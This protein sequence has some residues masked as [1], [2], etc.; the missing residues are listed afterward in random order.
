MSEGSKS[1]KKLFDFR[2]LIAFLAMV[3]VGCGGNGGGIGSSTQAT[4][5]HIVFN[6]GH[7][8]TVSESARM[9]DVASVTSVV[10]ANPSIT[11]SK[12]AQ[13]VVAKM[14]S[15]PDFRMGGISTSGD[16]WGEFKDGLLYA[17]DVSDP[18]FFALTP[19]PSAK[20]TFRPVSKTVVA[21]PTSLAST[22]FPGSTKAYIIHGVEDARTSP[23]AQLA[24]E[25]TQAGYSV[26]LTTG[27]VADWSQITHA[28]MLVNDGHGV[29]ILGKF[30]VSTTDS[31]TPLLD[32]QYASYLSTKAMAVAGLAVFDSASKQHIEQRYLLSID[33]LKS[34][35]NFSSMFAP[36]SFFMDVVCSGDSPEA[37]NFWGALQT[38][39]GLG[40]YS[41]WSQPVDEGAATQT[42]D[43]F[44]DRM[45]GLNQA[46][47]VDPSLPP[48]G[49]VAKTAALL[50]T[51]A[52]GIGSSNMDHDGSTNVFSF[53]F[54][55]NLT[56]FIPSI[57]SVAP[58]SDGSKWLV[59]GAFGADAGT[60]TYGGAPVAPVSWTDSEIV[61]PSQSTTGSVV[62]K[63]PTGLISNAFTPLGKP[64]LSPVSSQIKQ[65]GQQALKVTIG[66]GLKGA[67]YAYKWTNSAKYGTIAD[68]SGHKGTT[69]TSSNSSVTYTPSPNLYGIDNLTEE[70]F[71]V[72]TDGS[73]VSLGK[74]PA[75]VEVVPS[76]TLS[77]NPVSP[78]IDQTQKQAIIVSVQGGA[79]GATY[80]Y[81]WSNTAKFGG[82]A[83]AK[84][85]SGQKFT[86]PL[87][88]V[89]YT[90]NG[91]AGPDTVSV[92]V[93]VVAA[94]N[95]LHSLG[96]ER[97]EIS[98]E[99]KNLFFTPP[100]GTVAISQ[101]QVIS[102]APLTGSFPKGSSYVWSLAGQGTINGTEDVT[103]TVP[104]VTYKAPNHVAA[105]DLQV[106]VKDSSGKKIAD[107]DLTIQIEEV[108]IN[109]KTATFNG[110]GQAMSFSLTGTFPS[111]TKF[112]WSCK[113]GGLYTN[114]SKTPY[115]KTLVTTTPGVGFSVGDP[116][117]D[118]SPATDSLDVKVVGP[119]GTTLGT[120][121]A[122]INYGGTPFLIATYPNTQANKV[123]TSYI[124]SYEMD[125]L[126]GNQTVYGLGYGIGDNQ[127]FFQLNILVSS[128]TF[129]S[130]G[131]SY[132]LNEISPNTRP[133]TFS[134]GGNLAANTPPYKS[135]TLK[136]NS[137]INSPAGNG[138]YI[139]FSFTIQCVN[140]QTVVA[141]GVVLQH[142]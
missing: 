25:L 22:N 112:N 122:S 49:T 73:K 139:G 18:N 10:T 95:T 126:I 40:D 26:T 24:V 97:S 134:L 108:A 131:Q 99:V 110:G 105:A 51:T 61:L 46:A 84:G 29:N 50:A 66:N 75:T 19:A 78:S 87:D 120:T 102:V 62:V 2:L 4:G 45:L 56:H 9:S 54:K 15:L 74:I 33:Y 82:I 41:G 27:G 60:A 83:D 116:P 104:Q 129:L 64:T 52:R 17:V 140:G 31:E 71:L 43:F 53:H 76:G 67:T 58:S 6:N 128:G 11:A 34:L 130:P 42:A 32:K 109:P 65:G 133:D 39:S 137:E 88:D 70:T 57:S 68:A 135:G 47:P 115:P 94:D 90:P 77:I 12:M 16:P 121:S 5:D 142:S 127:G 101:S 124:P 93:F 14:Q 30:Y 98:V 114:G 37:A 85:H 125:N 3:V 79:T 1:V 23:S 63:T 69:F 113:S 107:G 48:P 38:A 13:L 118:G 141:N 136:I 103:T 89:T 100:D 8:G 111:G 35:P 106:T 123:G 119:T 55:G 44:F 59:E 80:S 81:N 7:T 91:K 28:G 117:A 21:R 72:Q 96:S 92:E 132:D 138:K 36:N 20:K 86:S